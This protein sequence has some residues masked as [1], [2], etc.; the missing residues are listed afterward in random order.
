MIGPCEIW[1]QDSNHWQTWQSFEY[2]LA[3]NPVVPGGM[4]LSVDGDA[5]PPW[6]EAST[7]FLNQPA[8]VFD[9]R[10]LIRIPVKN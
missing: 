7:R 2:F 4:L 6:G 1:L 9:T 10:K 8:I 3:W 5:S